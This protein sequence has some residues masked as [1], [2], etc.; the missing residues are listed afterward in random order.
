MRMNRARFPTSGCTATGSKLGHLVCPRCEA[1]ELQS[2][3]FYRPI[4]DSCG[5]GFGRA[6]LLTLAQIVVLPEALGKHACEECHH[7]QMRL[8]PDGV[9]HCPACGAEVLP[10][11][12]RA[13][14]VGALSS[15]AP[16]IP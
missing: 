14:R 3:A 12:S 8:L 4:C 5:C 9:F 16:P 1:G 2:D 11:I 7:P 15:S 13:L 6:V 10:L